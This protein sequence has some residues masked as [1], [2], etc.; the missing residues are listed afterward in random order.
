M[1]S[2]LEV[3]LGMYC[4]DGNERYRAV[5][6][7]VSICLF[8]NS[9]VHIAILYILCDFPLRIRFSCYLLFARNI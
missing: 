2:I 9:I 8:I 4:Y 6:N 3:L 1:S 5:V 7:T